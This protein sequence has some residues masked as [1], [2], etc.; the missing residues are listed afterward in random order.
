MFNVFLDDWKPGP[1][2]KAGAGEPDPLWHEWVVCRHID[3]VKKLLEL[4]LVNNLSLDHDLGVRTDTGELNPDGGELVKW[5]IEN[6]TWPKGEITIHS[7]HFT[8][9]K[10]MKADIDRFRNP[11]PYCDNCDNVGLVHAKTGLEVCGE[12]I[13][14]PK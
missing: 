13:H 5:M 6:S 2:N 14:K 12:D 11:Q 4:G 1:T 10:N 7:S 9:A 8:E 3:Q